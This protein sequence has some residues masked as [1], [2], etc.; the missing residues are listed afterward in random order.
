MI[1]PLTAAVV[2]KYRPGPKRR[3]IRDHGARSLFLVIEP[4]GHKSWQM[5]FRR[6]DGKGPGKLTLGPV[7]DGD[8]IAGAPVKG[9]P[10][11]LAGA[12]QLA[13]DIHRQRALG[14]DP[15][16]DHKAQK[17]RERAEQDERQAGAFAA[18]VRSF[19]DEHAKPKT[20]NWRE[21]AKLLG[22]HYPLDDGEPRE[23]KGGLLQRWGDK[24]VR[25]ID[26]HDIWNVID[27]ARR[28]GVPGLEARSPG[29][30]DARARG[31]FVALSS[32]FTWA[33]RHRLIE[34]NPCRTVP[35]PAAAKVRDR[36][37]TSDEV[38]W[39]WQATETA[40]A[41]RVPGAPKPFKALLRLLLLTGQRL[42]EVAGMTHEELHDNG[43]WHLAGSRTK[44]KKAHV[45]PLSPL[46]RDLIASMPGHEG[47]VFSTTGTSPVSGW[48]RMKRRLDAAML[49]LAKQERGG[50]FA[51][52]P[53]R[54]HDLR[55][56]AVTG[57]VELGAP[58]HVVELVVNHV[59]GH[60][61]GVAGVYN[62]S[63]MLPERKAALERWAAHLEGLVSGR[64]APVTQLAEKARGRRRDKA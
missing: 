56:T 41:P 43:S 52:P 36:V 48:S 8:E 61:A 60:K 23:T 59:S 3:R 42:D 54:L 11:T 25:D 58:P 14:G 38:R 22:L 37:L 27:E 53:W 32:F 49:A 62:K 6:P 30:S 4:S 9:M 15:L 45:V 57:M 46:A 63:E 34:I 1:K 12:R 18:S 13:A 55:R 20:R 5:R 47:L 28:I 19:I 29:K 64:S 44:N 17:H 24:P 51:I 31:L 40:D 10:L 33:Q 21:V 7:H 35:R 2:A 16:S 26:G 50:K 39:F